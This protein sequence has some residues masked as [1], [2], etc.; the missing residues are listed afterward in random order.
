[1]NTRLTTDKAALGSA[2]KALDKVRPKRTPMPVLNNILVDVNGAVRMTTT[3]MDTALSVTVQ[4]VGIDP[5]KTTE[6]QILLPGDALSRII[7]KLPSGEITIDVEAGADEGGRGSVGYDKG[8]IDLPIEGASQYPKLHD[9][10]ASSK[11]VT[12]TPEVIDTLRSMT[13]YASTDEFRPAMCGVYL[14]P[15]N[16]NPV[17]VA[18]D[19]LRLIRRALPFAIEDDV[20]VPTMFLTRLDLFD[21]DVEVSYNASHIRAQDETTTLTSRLIDERYPDWHSVV[22]QSNPDTIIVTRQKLIDVV[23]RVAVASNEQTSQVRLTFEPGTIIVE[24]QDTD[25]NRKGR[26]TITYSGDTVTDSSVGFNWRFLVKAL[27]S[28]GSD[29]VHINLPPDDG[30]GM[31]RP[32]LFK[33]N[34]ASDDFVLLMPIRL[35]T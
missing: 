6:G 20:I 21:G 9:F 11:A 8:S 16:G 1:M 27:E 22:P 17:A 14:D 15:N 28:I 25:T 29:A 19:G 24:A 31:L 10:T 12:L 26:E 13:D 33:S 34:P 32:S 2:I 5:T 18:T 7:G 35:N 3:D 30:K 4:G 23:Q